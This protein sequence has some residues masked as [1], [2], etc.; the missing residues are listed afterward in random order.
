MTAS[1]A[2]VVIFANFRFDD[3]ALMPGGPFVAKFRGAW[4]ARGADALGGEAP[5][6]GLLRFQ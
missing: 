2:L 4:V 3:S 1:R 5:S 6:Y